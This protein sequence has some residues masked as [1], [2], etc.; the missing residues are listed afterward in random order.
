MKDFNSPAEISRYEQSVKK[1][2]VVYNI[3]SAIKKLQRGSLALVGG[4]RCW[5]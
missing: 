2:I 3:G 5:D 4:I 1:I